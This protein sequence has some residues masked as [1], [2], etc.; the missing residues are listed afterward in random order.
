[1]NRL[2]ASAADGAAEVGGVNVFMRDPHIIVVPRAGAAGTGALTAAAS[3]SEFAAVLDSE[4]SDA[5][6]DLTRDWDE[7]TLTGT[8]SKIRVDGSDFDLIVT[9]SD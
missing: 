9:F 1:M 3:D 5:A 7:F 2:R 4:G 8:V 6:L